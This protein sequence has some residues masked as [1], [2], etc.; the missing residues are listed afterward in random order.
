AP[1]LP[2]LG[3]DNAIQAVGIPDKAEA[4]HVNLCCLATGAA[5]HVIGALP[6]GPLE[7]PDGRQLSSDCATRSSH[8]ESSDT[9]PNIFCGI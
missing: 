7:E 6:A 8:R 1:R 2:P 9:G 5:G 3:R 4:I